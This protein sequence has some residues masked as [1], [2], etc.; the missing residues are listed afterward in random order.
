[1]EDLA[2]GTW[3]EGVFGMLSVRAGPQI[4][5]VIAMASCSIGAEVKP[6]ARHWYR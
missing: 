6:M 1:M 5:L 3:A 4:R 2:G